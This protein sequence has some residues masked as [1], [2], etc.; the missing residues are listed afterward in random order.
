M[1]HWLEV[2]QSRQK[3]T[4]DD[5]IKGLMEKSRAQKDPTQIEMLKNLRKEKREKLKKERLERL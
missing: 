1:V 2:K 5:A 4:I 3:V